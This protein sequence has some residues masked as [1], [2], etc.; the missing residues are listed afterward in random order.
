MK[1]D[2]VLVIPALAGLA[3]RTKDRG[4]VAFVSEEGEPPEFLG[5]LLDPRSPR[6]AAPARATMSRRR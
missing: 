2:V 5:A 6:P 4:V 3:I 1:P